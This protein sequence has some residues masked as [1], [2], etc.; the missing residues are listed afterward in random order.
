MQVLAAVTSSN[1]LAV[2]QAKQGDL[3]EPSTEAELNHME[4]EGIQQPVIQPHEVALDPPLAEGATVRCSHC[5][6]SAVSICMIVM[7]AAWW[8]LLL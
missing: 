2:S 1:E 6:A 3:W 5:C 4:A 8:C 7:H